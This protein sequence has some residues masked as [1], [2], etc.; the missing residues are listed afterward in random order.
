[1]KRNLFTFWKKRAPDDKAEDGVKLIVGLGNPGQEYAANRH[2]IGFR[3]VSRFGKTHGINFDKKQGKARTGAG[4]V[5]GVPVMLARP[6]TFMNRSGESVALLMQKYKIKP[7]DLIVVHDDLDLPSGKVRLSS[8]SGSGGHKGIDSIIYYL[9]T[10]NFTRI[11]VGIGRPPSG[12]EDDIINYV[13][14]DF[15]PEESRLIEAAGAWVEDA[16]LCLLS[17]GL[18]AAMNRYN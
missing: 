14:G 2:N 16:L 9:N 4:E 6:Q 15:T 8:G 17:D 1:M 18:A 5:A 7:A 13:L 12:D 10:R 11:R 3:L